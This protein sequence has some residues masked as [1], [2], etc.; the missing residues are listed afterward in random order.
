MGVRAFAGLHVLDQLG[1]LWIG[2]VVDAHA[3]HV[4]L[5][6]LHAALAAVVAIARSLGR[7][8]EQVAHDR[9]VALRRDALDDRRDDRLCRIAHVP[10]R[11]AGEVALIGVMA[12]ERQVGVDER[13]AATAVELRR[14]RRERHE[15]HVARRD[16]GVEPARLE[17]A[18]WVGGARIALRRHERRRGEGGDEAYQPACTAHQVGLQCVVWGWAAAAVVYFA[19]SW[20]SNFCMMPISVVCAVTTSFAN[21][22]TSTSCPASEVLNR[23]STIL[24]APAWCWIII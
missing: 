9:R 16:A 18:P 15:P 21:T 7:E 24:S 23:S 5:R 4:V 17:V 10:H 13:E 22:F 3:R 14:L 2:Y 20:V 6:V 1:R 12:A 8:K 11:E 19:G